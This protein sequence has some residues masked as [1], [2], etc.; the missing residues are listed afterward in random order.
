MNA[1]LL[2]LAFIAAQF[3]A[4]FMAML[5][6]NWPSVMNGGGLDANDINAT[7]LGI[8]LFVCEGLLS[9]AV[10]YFLFYKKKKST[11]APQ[12]VLAG[13]DLGRRMGFSA[14]AIMLMGVGLAFLL[15][16]LHLPDGGTTTSFDAMKYNPICLLQLA[17]FGPLCEELVFRA[18]I[19]ESLVKK[20]LPGWA[21]VLISAFAFAVV[22]GNLAQ[23]LPAFIIGF[24]LGLL[25]LR[26]RSLHLCLT[27]H[28]AYNTLGVLQLF[29]PQTSATD[30]GLPLAA[31]L[32]IGL[33]CLA[34]GL[35]CLVRAL[36]PAKEEISA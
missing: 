11:A 35:P 15:D 23:G 7:S 6:S 21:A 32:L 8:S 3:A 20:N 33:L 12:P 24:A 5:L 31:T 26:T 17:L 25:Y 2:F 14:G 36:R 19:V 13:A 27:G 9:L 1:I 30:L 18:G 29:L 22:H 28:V 16:P 34:G 4:A 10:W